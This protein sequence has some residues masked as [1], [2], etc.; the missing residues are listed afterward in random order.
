MKNRYFLPVLIGS[1]HI[2]P[3]V[4][5]YCSCSYSITKSM[6]F[7]EVILVRISI[8]DGHIILN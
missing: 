6:H 2:K 5:V 4:L 8:Q 7:R 1:F 3:C